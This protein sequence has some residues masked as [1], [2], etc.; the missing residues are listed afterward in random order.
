SPGLW[1]T[2]AKGMISF[3]ILMAALWGFFLLIFS[4]IQSSNHQETVVIKEMVEGWKRLSEN[5]RGR[6]IYARPPRLLVLDLQTGR[7]QS[8]PHIEVEG[9]Q[10]RK[11][12]GLT[13]RPFF[14]PDGKQ[15]IY[16][17]R[18]RIWIGNLDGNKRELKNGLMDT[19]KETRWSWWRGNDIDWAVG[20]SKEGNIIMINISD[21]S[22]TKT[23][24]NGGDVKWWCEVTGNGKYVVYDT[25]TDIYVTPVED[26]SLAI[27]ISRRQSCRPCAAPDNRVAWLP[28]SH[29]RYHIFNAVNGQPLGKLLAPPNEGIYRLNWSN[30]PDFA[31]HMFGSA[32]N[33]RMHVRRIS[34]GG[35]VFIGYG[36]DPDLWVE[37]TN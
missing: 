9:G 17:Y 8:I 25:G 30:H 31:V 16:R 22:I 33:Q 1:V 12:R 21:P 6:V 32:E 36:W 26:R 13:P 2:L 3:L 19:T 37:S 14:A 20:P 18:D 10:G 24:Y 35:R 4:P 7:E 11:L 5:R 34:T 23:I 29:I 28:A 15:F 27:K